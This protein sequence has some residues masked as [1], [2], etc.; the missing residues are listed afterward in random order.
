MRLPSQKLPDFPT[1]PQNQPGFVLLVGILVVT[2]IIIFSAGQFGRVANFVRQGSNK[3]V[4][5]QAV[6]LAEAGVDYAIW[7][8]N[9]NAGNWFGS[10][11]EI[12]VGTTG[13][14]FVTVT[15]ESAN[16]KNVVAT[17][18]VPNS[19]SPRQKSTVKTQVVID[20]ETISFNYAVQVGNGGVRMENSA[21]IIGTVYSNKTG[22]NSIEGYNTTVIEGDAYASGT[23]TSPRP[24][25]TGTKYENRP[26]SGFPTVDYDYWKQAAQDGGTI[27]CSL[28][29]G[30]CSITTNKTIGPKKYAGN[31]TISNGAIVTMNGP[32]Y[33]TGIFDLKND[34]T[35]LKLSDSF[36]S[37]GSV[38][39]TDGQVI[40]QNG[41]SVL[42]TSSTPK[43][44]ILVVTTSTDL[45]KAINIK[46]SGNNAVFYALDGGAL[47]END[48]ISVTAIVAKQLNIKNNARLTYEEGLADSQFSTGP[49]GS[50]T[51]RK[52][53][54]Q[55]TK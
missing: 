45:D 33:V 53:S 24:A 10:G 29:P 20:T 44:Y 36:G 15:N 14:F 54:Y 32:L 52:G 30:E 55:Y 21:T 41:A 31:L 40:V 28:T 12:T 48:D 2:V 38:L 35:K 26:Q 4:Q 25:V 8:L 5:Q 1:S 39:I 27:D 42:P 22:G 18:Y 6:N 43:G 46:N 23:I 7:Q 19:T 11:V 3:V 13:T 50:W 16:I 17:G 51:I 9:E 49:G 47:I 34:N 37:N